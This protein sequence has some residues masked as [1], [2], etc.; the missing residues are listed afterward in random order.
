MFSY[1]QET[2]S[3]QVLSTGTEAVV[4]P[5]GVTPINLTPPDPELSMVVRGR[6]NATGGA[7]GGGWSVKLR[8]AAN[9]ATPTTG[10]TQVGATQ[11]VTFPATTTI[12]F[13]FSFTDTAWTPGTV[14]ALTLTAAGSNGTVNDVGLELYSPTPYG[15]DI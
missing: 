2:A 5:G 8:K 13:P 11:T 10:S 3:T 1:Y 12:D 9:N 15:T 6:V 7:T 4:S 14:Y